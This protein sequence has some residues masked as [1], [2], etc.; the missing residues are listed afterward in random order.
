M[1]EIDDGISTKYH[2]DQLYVSGC[3]TALWGLVRS[4]G[5]TSL[6]PHA[7]GTYAFW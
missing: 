5:E 3:R 6:Y 7:L 2:H 1:I 4:E